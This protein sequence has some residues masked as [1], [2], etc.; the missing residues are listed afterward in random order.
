MGALNECR[1]S[2]SYNHWLTLERS[3]TPSGCLSVINGFP[4]WSFATEPTQRILNTKAIQ[5]EMTFLV[6]AWPNLIKVFLDVQIIKKW[7]GK[8]SSIIHCT[9]SKVTDEKYQSVCSAGFRFHSIFIH[10]SEPAALFFTAPAPAP[11][12]AKPFR[13]LRLRLRLR[14]KCRLRRLRLRLR[15][16]LRIP[17]EYQWGFLILTSYDIRLESVA[18]YNLHVKDNGTDEVIC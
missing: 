16:R 14:P 9:C 4:K 6:M 7:Q 8:N 10:F 2:L 11:A 17:A 3:L 1:H 15:L 18:Q 12:P 5:P 13:R